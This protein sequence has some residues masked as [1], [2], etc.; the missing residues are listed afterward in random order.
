MK[1]SK[2]IFLIFSF[3][4]FACLIYL[5]YDISRRTDLPGSERAK[6]N[7]QESENPDD[8]VKTRDVNEL[9]NDLRQGGEEEENK[10]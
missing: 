7:V 9:H 5:G 8:S 2:K 1:R 3:V 4:F 6:E 10:Y